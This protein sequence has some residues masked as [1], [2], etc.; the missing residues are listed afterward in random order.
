[1]EQTQKKKKFNAIDVLI[2]IVIV[3]LVVFGGYKLL[4]RNRTAAASTPLTYTV[5]CPGVEPEVYEAIQEHI[6][7]PLLAGGD[8]VAG[9]QVVSVTAEPH[10][11]AL[12]TTASG[13]PVVLEKEGLLDLTFTIETQVL[14][15][16]TN[17]V[18][19]QEVRI[20]RAHIV[21]TVYFE[22]QNGIVLDCQWGEKAE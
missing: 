17:E 5:L 6:P 1:M 19:S 12:L 14:N 9:S 20:G 13:Q 8:L 21:K 3:A 18:G 7:S 15:A 2:V 22:L 10:Q 16:T 11:A 4:T